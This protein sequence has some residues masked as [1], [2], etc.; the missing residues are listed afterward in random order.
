MKDYYEQ[1]RDILT[2]YP[3]TRD[4]DMY[5]YAVFVAETTDVNS[6]HKF[7][8]VLVNHKQYNLPSYESVTRARRKVQEREFNL[9]G[10]KRSKRKER[11]EEYR[12][13]YGRS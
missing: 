8:D 3:R 12:E 1:V 6:N 9:R 5:L 13:Y 11:Q 7:F 4:D 10:T 2:L